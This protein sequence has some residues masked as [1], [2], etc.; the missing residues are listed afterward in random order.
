MRKRILSAVLAGT[1]A[2]TVLAGSVISAGAIKK[3]D[4]SYDPG[5]VEAN[6]YLF[7]MPGGWES[8]YWK[9]NE[10]RAGI[11][12]WTGPDVPKDNF[13]HEWPGYVVNRVTD[14]ENVKNLYSTPVPKETTMIIFNNHINGG[15][16]SK[17]QFDKNKFDISKILVKIPSQYVTVCF[18]H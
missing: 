15:M 8:D 16:S 17:T 1:L 14:E 5:S 3:D 10:N 4:D 18:A 2:A 13:T 7:A 9:Q 12:W 11:Y 6:T